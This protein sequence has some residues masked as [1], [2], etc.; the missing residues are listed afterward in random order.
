MKLME[1]INKAAPD[2]VS[3]PPGAFPLPAPAHWPRLI[4]M[5]LAPQLSGLSR[6]AL[7][8]A[9]GAGEL[10]AV[11]QGRSTLLCAHSLAAYIARLPAAQIG[12][13]K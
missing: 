5:R 4:A 11:K 12:G 8:R 7:Y 13:A 2:G 10:Q 3:V 1:K 6:S 9:I